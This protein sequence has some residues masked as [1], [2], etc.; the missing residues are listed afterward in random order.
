MNSRLIFDGRNSVW[1]MLKKMGNKN[2]TYDNGTHNNNKET[3]LTQAQN[4]LVDEFPALHLNTA[5]YL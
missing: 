4:G 5:R 2:A 3:A 1:N